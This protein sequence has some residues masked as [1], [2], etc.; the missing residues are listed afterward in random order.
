M[1][2]IHIYMMQVKNIL[3]FTPRGFSVK[4]V[5]MHV[6]GVPELVVDENYYYRIIDFGVALS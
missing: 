2:I 1:N 5:L 3:K 6:K 4:S